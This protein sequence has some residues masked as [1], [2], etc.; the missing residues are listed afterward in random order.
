M[1]GGAGK[2][3]QD[4][5]LNL[6]REKFDVYCVYSN[7]RVD[8]KFLEMYTILEKKAKMIQ[9]NSMTREIDLVKDWKSFRCITKII[10]EVNPDVVHCHS[11]KAGV[12]G[13]MAAK[14][15]KVERIFY[16]PHAYSFLAPEFNS[17]KK[18]VFINIEKVLS[19]FATTKTFTVSLG[20]KNEAIKAKVDIDDKFKVVYNGLPD[21]SIPNKI[22]IKESLGFDRSDFL[23]GTNAR[24]SE[25]KNPMLFLEIAKKVIKVDRSICFVIAGDGP[26]L[27][28]ANHFIQENNLSQNIRLLGDR[29]DCEILVAG[30]DVFLSTSLYE[31][32]PY[33][34]I[35][36]MRASVPI[37][38][39]NVTGN[40][41]VV[42]DS[43]NGYL[44]FV[45]E[46]DYAV[47]TIIKMKEKRLTIQ[48]EDIA[49]F[50]KQ[51]FSIDKML[52]S[53]TNEY[54]YIGEKQ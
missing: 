7:E 30:Y 53:I 35:E 17:F 38:A 49:N 34:P 37:I 44:F 2:H 26:L 23:V 29:N 45:E 47:N 39:T 28:K 4:L 36:A 19:K 40:N 12:V 46:V 21:I 51:T 14:F 8:K 5:I 9:C 16:T 24:L 20:E 48:C 15:S 11:S 31:G 32:L 3:V 43:I 52:E 22:N 50:F 18:L 13:R 41:E 42:R 33:A 10:K 54:K 1:S 27:E 25:Q 6:D